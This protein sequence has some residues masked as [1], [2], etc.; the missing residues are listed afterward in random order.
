LEE[1]WNRKEGIY[2]AEE[3]AVERRSERVRRELRE[4]IRIQGV[5]GR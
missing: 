4:R 3:E 5:G 1:E 2:G